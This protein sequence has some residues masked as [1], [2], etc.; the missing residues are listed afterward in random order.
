M[1]RM[2][3]EQEP[4]NKA[5]KMSLEKLVPQHDHQPTNCAMHKDIH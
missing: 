4:T 5:G 3:S 1:Y 2:H